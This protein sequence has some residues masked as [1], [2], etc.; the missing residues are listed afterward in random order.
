LRRQD[1]FFIERRRYVDEV[2]GDTKTRGNC[3]RRSHVRV[4]TK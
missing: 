1:S 2:G 4:L 3:D